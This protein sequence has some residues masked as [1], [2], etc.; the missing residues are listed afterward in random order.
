MKLNV[1][2]IPTESFDDNGEPSEDPR[3]APFRVFQKWMKET[4]SLAQV[5]LAAC[6]RQADWQVGDGRSRVCQWSVYLTLH[7]DT[8]LIC[9]AGHTGDLQGIGSVT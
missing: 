8:V 7:E 5:P 1:Q 6:W 3:W 9:R 2:R 4:F